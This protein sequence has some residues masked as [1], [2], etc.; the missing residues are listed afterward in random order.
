MKNTCLLTLTLLLAR[1]T[2]A[3]GADFFVSPTGSGTPPFSSWADAATNIQDAIDA[4]SAGDNVWVTNGL[5]NAGGKATNGA[6]T[7]RVAL[8]KALTV[9][10]INGPFLTVIQGAW[11]PVSTNGPLAVRCA[12]LTNGA[13]LKGF[14]LTGGATRTSGVTADLS[15]GGIWCSASNSLVAN[16]ILE[17]NAVASNGGGAYGG[18]LLSCAVLGNFGGTSS[19]AT[20]GSWLRNCTVVSNTCSGANGGTATNCIFYYNKSTDWSSLVMSHCCASFVS[21]GNGNITSSPQ[22]MADGIHLSAA[23][24]CLGAGINIGGATDIDGQPW[25]IPPSIGCDEYHGPPA[26]TLQPKLLFKIDPAGFRLTAALYAD[27]PFTCNWS[28]DGAPLV[29]GSHL[30]GT[31]TTNL[32]ANGL[33]VSDAGTYQLWVTNAYGITASAAVPLVI[34]CASAGAT[35]PTAPFLDWSTAAATIQ[36]AIDAAQPGE[37]VLVSDGVYTKGGRV[38]AGDLTN[39]IALNKVIMVQ[40]VSG[41][42]TTIIQGAQDPASTNGP[43]ALRCAWLTNNAV[44]SGFTLQGG[45]TRNAGD[46]YGAESG[47]GVW[48]SSSNSVVANCRLRGNFAAVGGGG[49]YRAGITASLILGNFGGS[50]G[51]AFYCSLTNSVLLGNSATAG[52]GANRSV[53][54]GCALLR[55]TAATGGGVEGSTLYSC[56]VVSNSASPVYSFPQTLGGGADNSILTNCIVYANVISSSSSSSNYNLGGLS[57]CCTAPL[58]PSGAGNISVDPQLAPDGVHLSATSPCIGAGNPAAVG[59]ADIDGQPWASPPSLGCDEFSAAPACTLPLQLS[60]SGFPTGLIISGIPVG[61]QPLSLSWLLNGSLLVDGP[62]Y[63]S[64]HNPGLNVSA[65]GPADAGSYQ[66]IAGNAFGSCTSSVAVV[67]VHCADPGGT[68]PMPPYSDWST[69]ATNLQD[70]VDAAG[71]GEFVL[72]TNGVYATGGRVMAGD[73]T[74]RVAINNGAMVSSINGPSATTIPGAH[75]PST[76]TGPQGIRCAWLGQGSTLRGFTL[77]DGATRNAGDYLALQSGGGAWCAYTNE[78]LLNCVLTNNLA[79]NSGGGSYQGT[80]NYCVVAGNSSATGGG[81]YYAALA[82]SVLFSNSASQSGGGAY[83][84]S[85]VDCTVTLNYAPSGTGGGLYGSRAWNSIIYGNLGAQYSSVNNDYDLG[86]LVGHFFSCWTTAGPNDMTTPSPQ[87]LPDHIHIAATSPCRGAGSPA[88][89]TGTDLDGEPWLN[90][91]SIGCKEYYAADFTGP[92]SVGPITARGAWS[93]GPVLR[94]GLTWLLAGFTGNADR[95]AWSFGDGTVLTNAYS[96]APGHTWTNAGDFNVSFTAYNSD[97]P[98]GV[99]TNALIHVALPD[100]P[101]LYPNSLTGSTFTINLPMQGG[102]KYYIDQTTNLAP[103]VAWQSLGYV[104]N[105]TYPLSTGV[106]ADPNATNAMRFYRIRIQ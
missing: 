23:S 68:G 42:A 26:L 22:L 69:A 86:S 9:Q 41:P 94:N 70:A 80:L 66:L 99:S 100:P 28:K 5:Y 49:A 71:F 57:W 72:A 1:L 25:A 87:L 63:G 88:Y 2:A 35:N 75:D 47:G 52:G 40:S 97:N 61:Q 13:M 44:L 64:T 38:M 21:A 76:G 3:L 36:D 58:P 33:S 74:N 77:R 12:W 82:G 43:L 14:T 39:R 96:W 83:L 56:T 92:I 48:G 55:N 15:G 50:G 24:A 98:D 32:V 8:D 37:F 17:T 30:S 93:G 65:F 59:L 102:V 4:A 81:A 54:R 53:L 101:L 45:A 19:G 105:Y 20:Y 11:D 103:P 85:L 62:K 18:T 104:V 31:Q 78:S 90:P 10:S 84:S 95:L 60:F 106:L 46:L 79:A 6:L 91:P 16:C 34:H 29:E 89:A 51:G 73:L 7:N 27:D 67:V